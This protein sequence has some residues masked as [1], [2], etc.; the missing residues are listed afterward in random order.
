MEFHKAAG[1]VD[2]PDPLGNP[3]H[4]VLFSDAEI[5][6]RERERDST[7]VDLMKWTHN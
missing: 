1:I 7:Y 6:G 5:R 4:I 3:E 2:G